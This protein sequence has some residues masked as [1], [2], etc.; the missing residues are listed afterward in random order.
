MQRRGE[1]GADSTLDGVVD[2]VNVNRKVLKA[3]IAGTDSQDAMHAKAGRCHRDPLD[4]ASSFA[5]P[6][7]VSP[8]LEFVG[9]QKERTAIKIKGLTK[10]RR[11]WLGDRF[12]AVSGRRLPTSRS[13]IG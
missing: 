2:I 13:A 7:G 3:K 4:S 6:F 8:K 5:A 12:H 10:I 1:R 9:R 11:L